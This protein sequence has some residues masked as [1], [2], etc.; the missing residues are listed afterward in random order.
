MTCAELLHRGMRPC[1]PAAAFRCTV[2]GT[3]YESRVLPYSPAFKPAPAIHV[4][5]HLSLRAQFTIFPLNC[6]RSLHAPE[7]LRDLAP[8]VL[9]HLVEPPPD[10]QR[11]DNFAKK[12]KRQSVFYNVGHLR[13]T[14]DFAELVRMMPQLIRPFELAILKEIGLRNPHDFSRPPHGNHHERIEHEVQPH[15]LVNRATSAPAITPQKHLR[16]RNPG[17]IVRHR[18]KIPSAVNTHR[19]IL[20]PG[21]GMNVH[22]IKVSFK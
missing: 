1:L 3:V 10:D 12:V 8:P 9:E 17:K 18:K 20:H 5:E 4:K 22:R 15:P 21:S 19:H 14:L 16:R 2:A 6:K 13:P 11:I 7:D